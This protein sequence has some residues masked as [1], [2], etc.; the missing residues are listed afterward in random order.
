MVKTDASRSGVAGMLLQQK[1]DEWKIVACCS[2]RLNDSE[3]NYGITDLEGLAIVYTLQK[4]R[5]YCRDY[6]AL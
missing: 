3:R 6:S 1:N 4:F 2:R 5:P